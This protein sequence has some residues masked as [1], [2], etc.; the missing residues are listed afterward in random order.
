ME[1]PPDLGSLSGTVGELAAAAFAAK[2]RARRAAAALPIEQKLRVL[3]Q[4]QR[5]AN[6][7][8]RA[9]GRREIYVWEWDKM[10]LEP[11]PFHVTPSSPSG[12]QAPPDET[13]CD[14]S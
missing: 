4:L 3:I 12:V 1:T 11:R 14:R 2:D 6:E 10:W 5:R 7:V 9:T 13:C 8:R